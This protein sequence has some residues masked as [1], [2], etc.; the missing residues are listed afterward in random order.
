[1]SDSSAKLNIVSQTLTQRKNMSNTPT[2]PDGSPAASKAGKTPRK[3]RCRVPRVPCHTSLHGFLLAAQRG[4]III[5]S[6][7]HSTGWVVKSRVPA[8]LIVRFSN[9]E[10][11]VFD[12]NIAE[13]YPEAIYIIYARPV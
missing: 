11:A 8:G 2:T 13:S 10:T 7:H 5:P 1:M 12:E 9:G 3:A 4:D 6:P